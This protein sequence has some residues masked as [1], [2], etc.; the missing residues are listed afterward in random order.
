MFRGF[1][2]LP[3]KTNIPFL[4][5]RRIYFALSI[6]LVLGSIGLLVVKGLNLGIDFQ[7]GILLEVRTSGPADIAGMR[8]TLSDLQLGEATLQE[9]GSPDTI[10]IRLQRQEGGEEAQQTAVAAVKGALGSGV[11]Y[12]RSEF[13]GPQVSE[14]LLWDGIYAVTAAML[15]IM[16]YIWFRFEWEFGVCGVIALL[17]DVTTALGVLSLLGIE[18]NLATVAA[19]LTIAGYSIND[20]VVIFDRVRENLRRYKKMPVEDVMN[21]S[22]NGTLPRTLMTSLTTLLTLVALYVLGGEV[23]RGFS[24]ALMWGVLIGTYSSI[25][26]AV[27]LL[28]AFNVRPSSVV[29][30][31]SQTARSNEP[32]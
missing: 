5:G 26:L 13:V 16:V 23:L 12:R 30:E 8:R 2:I 17:H 21:L 15:A 9:F 19:I 29:E 7:G 32:L 4:A 11:E 18:F 22:L 25:C 3:S 6:F 1:R 14:E 31:G 28:L 24:F 27:P 10:L 20:T